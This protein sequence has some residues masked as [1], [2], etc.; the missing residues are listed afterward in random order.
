MEEELAVIGT[1]ARVKS[2]EIVPTNFDT[3]L[4]TDQEFRDKIDEQHNKGKS[5][6]EQI[7]ELDKIRQFPMDYLHCVLLGVMRIFLEIWFL[8][9]G[10]YIC[11]INP[12]CLLKSKNIVFEPIEINRWLRGL[13]KMCLW[14]G[15]E[16]RTFLLFI[17]P[18]VL[19]EH[20]SCLYFN[21]FML[22]HVAISIQ[23]K[24]IAK[25]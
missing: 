13:D 25:I 21:H 18:L 16:L 24:N 11:T 4:R 8:D 9:K 22:L 19:K 2:S 17:G 5:E 23:Y 6:F 15:E 1:N 20:I 14:K 3:P 12:E 7:E 10:A